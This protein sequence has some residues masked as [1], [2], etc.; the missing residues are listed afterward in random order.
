[1][2][3]LD[4]LSRAMNFWAYQSAQETYSP[5]V[6]PSSMLLALPLHRSDLRFTGIADRRQYHEYSARALQEK[7]T[8]LHQQYD[9]IV[10]DSSAEINRP[11]SL[12]VLVFHPYLSLTHLFPDFLRLVPFHRILAD[13]PPSPSDPILNNFSWIAYSRPPHS[14]SSK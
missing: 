10:R 3:I 12:S 5:R 11:S 6:H 9:A 7:Y 13:R 4:I 1:M 14:A 2:N 8:S